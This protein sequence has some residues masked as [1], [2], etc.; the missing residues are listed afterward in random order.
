MIPIWSFLRKFGRTIKKG[1]V[2]S[3]ISTF[4]V[5]LYSTFS[6]Y[7][8]ERSLPASGIHSL[9]TS[10]WW[11]MQTITTVGYGD[12]SVVGYL[13]RLNAVIIMVFGIGSIGYLLASVSANIVNSRFSK[14]IGSVRLRMRKH[15]VVCNFDDAGREVISTLNEKGIPVVVVS[16]K[17]VNAEGIDFQYVKGSCLDEMT[18]RNAGVAKCETVIILAGKTVA[19]GDSGEIDASTIL[20]GMNIKKY[21]PEAYIIAEIL[22]TAN[23]GHAED[24]GIDEVIV[25]GKLSSTLISNSILA[26]GVTKIMKMMIAGSGENMVEE[27]NLHKYR[28][29]TFASV[30]EDFNVPGKFILGFRKG[31]GIV[32][33]LP[34]DQAVDGYSLILLSKKS[35]H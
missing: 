32:N 24:A 7:Y 2:G 27:I 34:S 33:E 9:F 11:T 6:E 14:R 25:K 5:V 16:K 18:L 8:L 4:I 13:G 10:F 17:E 22:D 15:V 21:N 30:Y 23:E 35:G 29:K 31:S 28:G 20:I 12:T 19:N 1:I 3:S 26:P